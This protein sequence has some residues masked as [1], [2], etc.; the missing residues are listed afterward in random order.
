ME[1]VSIDFKHMQVFVDLDNPEYQ[2]Q[3]KTSSV[4]K[5]FKNKIFVYQRPFLYKERE[6]KKDIKNGPLGVDVIQFWDFS[7]IFDF[8]C[9]N[10]VE[11][12]KEKRNT[13]NSFQITIDN[14]IK[15]I[16]QE[17][18][19]EYKK[20]LDEDSK[21]IR[22]RSHVLS[23]A[24]LFNSYHINS[25]NKALFK[26]AAVVPELGHLFKSFES[27][28]NIMARQA[29]NM[30]N[31]KEKIIF[32]PSS[33]EYFYIYRKFIGIEMGAELTAMVDRDCIYLDNKGNICKIRKKKE[34]GNVEEDYIKVF[35]YSTMYTLSMLMKREKEGKAYESLVDVVRVNIDE[36]NGTFFENDVEHSGYYI[37]TVFLNSLMI[38]RNTFILQKSYKK[39]LLEKSQ[40]EYRE[41][42]KR[43]K[44][45]N[46]IYSRRLGRRTDGEVLLE[47]VKC[48]DS[49]V[50]KFFIFNKLYGFSIRTITM[51]VTN[52]EE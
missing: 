27:F 12:N 18:F 1:A 42:Y 6:A 34:N 25:E 2:R 7:Y 19:L 40:K 44:S 10:L 5:N 15:E 28:I 48:S 43:C 50:Y 8:Y 16:E 39:I 29:N 14:P 52:D 33:N 22:E 9:L 13:K 11:S 41:R 17:Y 37:Q 45:L 38:I 23:N 3:V 26:D 47:D 32:A 49:I 31:S 30:R 46:T 21:S 51:I 4:F 24:I 35:D 36:A 20:F